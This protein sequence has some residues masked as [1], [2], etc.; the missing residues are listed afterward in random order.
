MRRAADVHPSVPEHKV[1]EMHELA[2]VP[3]RGAGFGEVGPLGPTLGE[4][5]VPEPLVKARDG[6]FGALKLRREGRPR[7]V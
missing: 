6:V 7:Q 3:E 5:V 4:R 1:F 2:F